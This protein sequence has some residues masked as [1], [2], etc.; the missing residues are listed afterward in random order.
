MCIYVGGG[1]RVLSLQWNVWGRFIPY[2]RHGATVLV[3]ERSL[4]TTCPMFLTLG[5]VILFL[6]WPGHYQWLVA[7]M[8]TVWLPLGCLWQRNHW[9]GPNSPGPIPHT[10]VKKRFIRT[11]GISK[12][13]IKGSPGWEGATH[14]LLCSLHK[15]ASRGFSIWLNI[16][17]KC[18]GVK[19][20]TITNV[21]EPKYSI[22]KWELF[23]R[24]NYPG[25][26]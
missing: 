5:P 9:R 17:W 23:Q 19:E 25:Y 24:E 20:S 4:A 6:F 13:I 18:K 10:P 2:I 21:K 12:C 8:I 15:H 3:C 1:D 22:L 26:K 7:L 14:H 16:Y 11:G